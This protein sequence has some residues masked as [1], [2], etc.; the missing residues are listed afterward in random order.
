MKV[1]LSKRAPNPR[2]VAWVLAEKGATEVEIVD[3][4]LLKGEHKD[5]A[6]LGK[7]GIANVPALE[8]DDG[9]VITESVAMLSEQMIAQSL[10][11]LRE[12]NISLAMDDFGTGYSS[13]SYLDR[14]KFDRLKVDRSFVLQM[15][16]PSGSRISEL[17]LQL[18]HKLGVRVIAEGIEDQSTLERLLQ[19]GCDEGQGYH[20]G[21]PMPLEQL[22]EWV[23]AH[24]P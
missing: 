20:I 17:I 23:R 6:F 8:M 5:P 21:R 14:L 1:Y 11:K 18:G 24:H 3:V 15:S 13:L 2:R 4:D 22:L 12:R 7:V 19:M 10:A 16:G 9:T